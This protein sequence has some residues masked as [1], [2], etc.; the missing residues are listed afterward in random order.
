LA[1]VEH[2]FPRVGERAHPQLGAAGRVDLTHNRNKAS[3]PVSWS[4]APHG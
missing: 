2:P 4:G 1:D 3:P